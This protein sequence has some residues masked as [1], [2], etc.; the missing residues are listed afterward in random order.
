M[1]YV[2]ILFKFHG[3]EQSAF[4]TAVRILAGSARTV[5]IG[6]SKE[7]PIKEQRMINGAHMLTSLLKAYMLRLTAWLCFEVTLI[8]H[9]A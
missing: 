9:L 8:F 5:P 6:N 4:G 3:S 2:L 7:F 1:P